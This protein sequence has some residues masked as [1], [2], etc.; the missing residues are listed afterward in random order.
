M[1]D[2]NKL[3]DALESY[4]CETQSKVGMEQED[5][6]GRESKDVD[7]YVFEQ[8]IES[9][10]QYCTKNHAQ[11]TIER[12]EYEIGNIKYFLYNKNNSISKL[13]RQYLLYVNARLTENVFCNLIPPEIY[14]FYRKRIMDLLYPVPAIPISKDA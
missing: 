2:L 13:T 9:I 14:I 11:P 3:K 6:F 1:E 4:N 10:Y 12:F 8:Q 5:L 7:H